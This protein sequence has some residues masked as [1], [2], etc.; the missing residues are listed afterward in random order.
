MQNKYGTSKSYNKGHILS[1]ILSISL[2][3]DLVFNY[4]LKNDFQVVI[5]LYVCPSLTQKNSNLKVTILYFSFM[6]C[7]PCIVTENY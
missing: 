3:C 1:L 6:N 5:H 4:V 7:M 2:L